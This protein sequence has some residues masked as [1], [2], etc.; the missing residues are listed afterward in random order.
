MNNGKIYYETQGKKLNSNF[1][2][3]LE[4]LTA[5]KEYNYLAYLI[6]D[7]NSVS[8]KVAKYKGKNKVDLLGK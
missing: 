4:L 8:C 6:S 7:N 1:A 2:S 3:N 5:N